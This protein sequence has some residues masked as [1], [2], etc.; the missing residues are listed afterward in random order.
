MLGKGGVYINIIDSID[1][2][3]EWE[4]MHIHI[5][6]AISMINIA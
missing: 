3:I 4:Y 1:R 6:V 5:P 2:V